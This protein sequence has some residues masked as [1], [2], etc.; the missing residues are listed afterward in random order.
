MRIPRELEKQAPGNTFI[1]I[2]EKRFMGK[3]TLYSQEELDK[4]IA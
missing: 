3:S 2:E 1:A 4:N